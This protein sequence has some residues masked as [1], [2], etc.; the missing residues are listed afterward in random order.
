MADEVRDYAKTS[1]DFKFAAS[2]ASFGMLLRRS[3]YRGTATFDAVLE[4]AQ[5]GLGD[6]QAGYRIEFVDLVRKTKSL[7]RKQ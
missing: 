2:V 1:G 7:L 3:E 5:E 6:D 4:L